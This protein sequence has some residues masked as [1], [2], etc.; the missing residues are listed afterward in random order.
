VKVRGSLEEIP[1]TE[2][3]RSRLA[4]EYDDAQDRGEIGRAGNSSNREELASVADIGLSHKDIHEAR[5]IRD[6]RQGKYSGVE[7]FT[8][9]TDTCGI[10]CIRFSRNQS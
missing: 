4:D 6:A 3:A 1:V 8:T 7:C 2:G 5:Q 10:A 9:T